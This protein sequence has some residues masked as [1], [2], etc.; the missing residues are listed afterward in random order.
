VD[1]LIGHGSI[2]EYSYVQSSQVGPVA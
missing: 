2:Y 1:R